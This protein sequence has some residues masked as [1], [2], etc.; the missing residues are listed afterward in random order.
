MAGVGSSGL[1]QSPSSYRARRGLSCSRSRTARSA[2]ASFRETCILETRVFFFDVYDTQT[3]KPVNCPP[4]FRFST[5]RPI[6][7]LVSVEEAAGIS[8]NNIRPGEERFAV[9]EGTA[10]RLQREGAAD[11]LFRIPRRPKPA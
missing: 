9:E 1:G 8:P 3:R 6:M 4:S 11:F 7:R 10:C 5:V 2:C